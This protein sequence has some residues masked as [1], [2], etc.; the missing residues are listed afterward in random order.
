MDNG[1]AAAGHTRNDEVCLNSPWEIKHPV[2]FTVSFCS[3]TRKEARNGHLKHKAS[4]PRGRYTHLTSS[5]GLAVNDLLTRCSPVGKP[6]MGDTQARVIDVSVHY[7]GQN[8][9]I[10]CRKS[11]CLEGRKSSGDKNRSLGCHPLQNSYFHPT[12]IPTPR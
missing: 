5:T 4:P 11:E 7:Q 6:E 12:P 2:N 8:G 1:G 10:L 9:G 3:Q